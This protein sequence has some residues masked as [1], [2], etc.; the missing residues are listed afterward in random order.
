M[1][2]LICFR[3]FLYQYIEFLYSLRL[4]GGGGAIAPLAPPKS[5]TENH[6]LAFKFSAWVIFIGGGWRT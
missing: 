6:T 1:H 4:S 5:A 2:E 3:A